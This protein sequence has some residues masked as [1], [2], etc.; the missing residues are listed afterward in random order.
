MARREKPIV[1]ELRSRFELIRFIL[2]QGRD[3]AVI[4]LVQVS[5]HSSA[6][7]TKEFLV[8]FALREAVACTTSEKFFN[9]LR[10]I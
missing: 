4:N 2:L 3:S 6:L 10:G 9:D 8:V 1:L 7:K 5:C